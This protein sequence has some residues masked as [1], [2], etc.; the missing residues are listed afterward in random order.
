M[1]QELLGHPKIETE[2]VYKAVL[3]AIEENMI[4]EVSTL[5]DR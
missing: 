5:L 1:V 4:D 2:L 3:V